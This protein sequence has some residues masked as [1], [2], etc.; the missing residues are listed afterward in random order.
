M[1]R[2]SFKRVI[3]LLTPPLIPS[4]LRRLRARITKPEWEYV[5]QGWKRAERDPS[6]KGWQEQSILDSYTSRWKHFAASLQGT[7]PF[8]YSIESDSQ[9]AKLSFHNVMM[10][11]AYALNLAAVGKDTICLLDW[12]GGLG[13][14]ALVSKALRP[15]LQIEY[16]CKELPLFIERGRELVPEGQFHADETWKAFRYDLAL[17]SS[18]IQ[19]DEDWRG[20]LT[21]IASVTERYLFV[22]R[23]PVVHHV[24]SFVV[25]Q[26]P[27]NYG[28]N[29]E[30]LGWCLNR[31]EVIDHAEV[32]GLKLV[33]EFISDPPPTIVGAPEQCDYWGFLFERSN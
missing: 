32:L 6:V 9:E 27:Y 10:S 15:D 26:R 24:P 21:D 28:Y 5:V 29:T 31:Q 13:H 18:S 11:Y 25:V 1:T 2:L 17:A 3:S 22:T 12:G 16:H 20:T 23:T 30:Y 8:G 19:Y 4:V 7:K 14:Y 33:R